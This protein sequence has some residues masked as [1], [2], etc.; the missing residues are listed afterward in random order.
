MYSLSV[1][2]ARGDML[3][4]SQNNNYQVLKVEGLNPPPANVNLTELSGMDGSKKN[5]AKIPSRN[6]VIYIKVLPPVEDNRLNLYRYFRT[7]QD[8]TI[9]FANNSRDV[10]IEGTIETIECPLFENNQTMQISILCPQPYFSAVDYFI[11]EISNIVAMFE[12]PFSIEE[13]GQEFSTYD[14]NRVTNVY[15][16]GDVEIGFLIRIYA[17]NT[18]SNPTIWN[19]NTR[20]YFKVNI[21]LSQYDVLEIC[22][23]KGQRSLKVKRNGES[24]YENI[25][26]LKADGSTWLTLLPGCN[27]FTYTTS[28]G[29]ENAQVEFIAYDLYQGV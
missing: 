24:N 3:N 5:F 19:S 27:T 28:V 29:D 9:Y 20:D 10:F 2:N 14:N 8:C 16:Q 6:L 7:G 13:S 22:T 11:A 26:N 12:F 17:K 15:N 4:L 25:I 21:T 23:I 18:L 1:K